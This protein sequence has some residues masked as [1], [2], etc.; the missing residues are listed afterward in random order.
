M[1]IVDCSSEM[2][3]PV[4]PFEE[5]KVTILTIFQ[6]VPIDI[7][8]IFLLPKHRFSQTIMRYFTKIFSFSEEIQENF[9]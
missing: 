1:K 2:F 6:D 4:T 7:Y 8:I 3:T 5:K 9:Q